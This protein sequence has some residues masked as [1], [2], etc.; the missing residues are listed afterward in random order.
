MGNIMDWLA[1]GLAWLLNNIYLFTN[2]Y[3][4]SIILTT[5]LV[6][7]LL[8]PLTVSQNKNMAAMRKLQ[9]EIDAI[10]KK[11]K[12]NKEEYQKR[13]MELYQ[14]HKVNPLGG[15][16][17]LLLQLPIL[18]AF[19]RVLR[20]LPYSEASRFLGI[21]V[22]SEPD[23]LFIL[24][25]IV[26]VSTYFQSKLANP[27]PSQKTML[28]VMPLILGVFSLSFPSGLVLYLITSNVFSVVQQIWLNRMYP[29]D[30]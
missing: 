10:Q 5:I 9:P 15:C 14:K 2:S 20:E 26:A 1:G 19:F 17:P 24:P 4:L 21:W 8:Y 6:R 22:L 13:T 16:F 7:L 29:I 27:D 28:I 25:V 12:D 11:Y 3:G 23:K 18:W 30:G